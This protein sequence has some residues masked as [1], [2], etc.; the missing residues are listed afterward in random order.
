MACADCF[1]A[2]LVWNLNLNSLPIAFTPNPILYNLN[3]SLYDVTDGEN[4]LLSESTSEI[5]N[6]EN[7][8]IRLVA[9]RHYE[10]RVS[11]SH[12]TSFDWP[13]ALAWRLD[14]TNVPNATTQI[15]VLSISM[16]ALLS[17]LIVLLGWRMRA[18]EC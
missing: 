14:T 13:Y 4:I 1:V 3:L 9:N 8:R 2:S 11:H 5:D 7:I 18:R 15:P 6:T 12:Q 16:S 17:I 10:L